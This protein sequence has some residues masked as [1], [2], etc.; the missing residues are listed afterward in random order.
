[1]TGTPWAHGFRKAMFKDYENGDYHLTSM[2]NFFSIVAAIGEMAGPMLC[3]CNNFYLVW[4]GIFFIVCMHLYIISSLIIDVFPWNCADAIWY[5]VLFG[6]LNTGTDWASLPNLNPLMV[7][8]LLAHMLYS[9]Y[10]NLVPNNVPYV[11]A[12]RHAAGNFTMG[13]LLVKRSAAAK[14]ANCKVHAGAPQQGPGWEG[15]WFGFYAAWAY[16]WCWNLPAKFLLPLVLDTMG[17]Q[18]HEDYLM[19]VTNLLFESVCAHL[20]F[21]ALSSLQLVPELGKVCGFEEGEAVMCWVGA[22]QSWPV[23]MLTTPKASWK[24]VDSKTGLVKEGVFDVK[25]LED[26]EYKKP[27]DCVKIMHKFQEKCGLCQNGYHA[28]KGA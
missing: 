8:W 13:I 6:I 19:V 1:M 25:S 10:G 24:V 20:R 9:A 15:A 2:A 18:S 5:V 14:L 11:V 26:I 16:F 17:N 3:L 23:P 7:A 12:H 27:S 4:L 21:D 28:L 22:F